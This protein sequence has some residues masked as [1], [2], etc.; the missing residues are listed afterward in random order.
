M[1]REIAQ[2]VSV[3][4]GRRRNRWYGP[5]VSGCLAWLETSRAPRKEAVNWDKVAGLATVLVVVALG[6]TA[7]GLAISHFLR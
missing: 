5:G 6:W 4:G 7:V 3:R 2:L 1:N